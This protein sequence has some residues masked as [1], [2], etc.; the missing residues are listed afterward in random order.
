MCKYMY[1][2]VYIYI[3]IYEYICIFIYQ[4][5]IVYKEKINRII[6]AFS[7]DDIVKDNILL[8]SF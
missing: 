6:H 7:N 5:M 2:C 3:Y 8:T 4:Y 1:I